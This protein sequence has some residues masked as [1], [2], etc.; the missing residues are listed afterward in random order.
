MSCS[1]AHI[2]R[3]ILPNIVVI[4]FATGFLICTCFFVI[5]KLYSYYPFLFYFMQFLILFFYGMWLWCWLYAVLFDPGRTEDDLR[6]R[7]LLESIREGNIPAC[8]GHLD[9]CP[10]CGLPKPPQAHHCSTCGKCHLRMDHH[11]GVTGQCVADKNFKAF[12]LSFLYAFL[13]GFSMFSGS[14]LT[15]C[16]YG[17]SIVAIVMAMYSL[18]VGIALLVFGL[19]TFKG[20]LGGSGTLDRIIGDKNSKSVAFSKMM[21]SCGCKWTQRLIPIQKRT[22]CLA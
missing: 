6:E 18:C 8:L 5:P 13:Y 22:T 10:K 15:L 7:G 9:I 14:I 11:C 17:T 19:I 3:A 2:A 1:S 20:A 16:I 4:G 21:N 12:I